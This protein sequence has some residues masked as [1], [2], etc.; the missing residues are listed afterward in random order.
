[1]KLPSINMITQ[2]EFYDHIEEDDD[3]AEVGVIYVEKSHIIQ[4]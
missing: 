3:Y 2:Q 1:M 4:L